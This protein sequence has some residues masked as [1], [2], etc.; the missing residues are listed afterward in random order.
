M[1]NLIPSLEKLG[2]TS[3]EARLY[4]A[5]LQ[6][7]KSPV[8]AIA[9]ESG[10]HREVV[11][12]GL[13][14]LQAQG[15]VQSLEKKKIRHYQAL[16]PQ[17]LLK[18]AERKFE[19]AKAILP[20]LKARFSQPPLSV[21]I[22]EGAEGFEETQQ[23]ILDSL[24]DG[25]EYCVIGASGERWYLLTL[26]FYRKYRKKSLERGITMKMVTVQEEAKKILEYEPSEFCTL[27]ILP[28]GFASVPSD[29]TVYAD[30]ILIEVV[31]EEPV[32]IQLQSKAISQSYREYFKALWKISKPVKR[33]A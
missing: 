6:F 11:Y 20:Q 33:S 10:L 30:K 18:K 29:T 13:A 9:S 27:R 19:L 21:R 12:T 32:T 22:F 7:G 17:E 28:K 8:G 15:L 14:K 25:E 1:T 26:P 2:L 31:G 16:H 24:K 23:D 3:Q 4:L 5:L